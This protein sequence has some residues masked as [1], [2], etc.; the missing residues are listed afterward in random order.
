[1]ILLIRSL[2]E[3][4]KSHKIFP[5]FI[6]HLKKY[7]VRFEE[8]L[9]FPHASLARQE[10]LQPFLYVSK[11]LGI[12]HTGVEVHG[13]EYV[14][15]AHDYPSSGVF[16]VEPRQC[17]GFMFKKSIFMG[18]TCLDSLQVREFMELQSVNYSGDTYHLIMKN[19]NHFCKEICHKMTG[20]LCKC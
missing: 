19:C 11:G 20:S 16:E 13:V 5:L 15:G 7:E 10:I 14:F 17:P 8:G 9:K 18:T 1:M 2:S 6:L 4:F 12:F 3:Y